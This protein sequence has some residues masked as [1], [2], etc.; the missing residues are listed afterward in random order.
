MT[1]QSGGMELLLNVKLNAEQLGNQL[2]GV[3]KA[4][5]S[6]LGGMFGAS[7]GG[8]GAGAATWGDG[9]VMASVGSALAKAFSPAGV[10]TAIGTGMAAVVGLFTKWIM[11]SQTFQTMAGGVFKILSAMADL[12]LMPFIPL[13][14]RFAQWMISN[15]PQMLAAGQKVADVVTRFFDRW[16]ER[17]DNQRQMHSEAVATVQAGPMGSKEKYGGGFKGGV[18]S[19]AAFQGAAYEMDGGMAAMPG[20]WWSNNRQMG[21]KVPGSPGQGVPTMLH[22]G[23]IV[24]PQDIAAG[25][26]QFS[27]RVAAWIERFQQKEL[28]PGGVL[29]QWYDKMFG[30][31]IIP[32]MWANIRGMFVSMQEESATTG[33]RIGQD[34]DNID[35]DQKSFWSKFKFWESW[36]EIWENI[37][38]KVGEW[39][40]LL[41]SKLFG[42]DGEEELPPTEVEQGPSISER[43]SKLVKGIGDWYKNLEIP[44]PF[45]PGL[46]IDVSAVGDCIIAAAKYVAG[47]FSDPNQKWSLPW[48]AVEGYEKVKGFLVSLPGLAVEG[49]EFLWECLKRIPGILKSFFTETI[50]GWLKS[51]GS[52]IGG[53]FAKINFG[54]IGTMI[55]DAI[56]GLWAKI[57]QVVQD[58]PGAIV[59]FTLGLV[60]MNKHFGSITGSRVPIPAIPAPGM[61]VPEDPPDKDPDK[62][63]GG[64]TTIG[65]PEEFVGSREQDMA[66]VMS[67]GSAGG[68]RTSKY[69]DRIQKG[70]Q[71]ERDKAATP[72]G[73]SHSAESWF[74]HFGRAGG[75]V[76][77]G[78]S[79]RTNISNKSINVTVNSSLS[80]SEI[81]EDLDRM[82]SMD[83]ASFFNSVM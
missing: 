31:S 41:M 2:G 11:S 25:S 45:F 50:P 54:D 40:D 33:N 13:M 18:K 64:G 63:T 73:W 53:W 68:Y 61:F 43:L 5:P 49:M 44:I 24:I 76:G 71:M 66:S 30:H 55:G 58:I 7:Q 4:L 48:M 22:G 35:K 75:G 10:I 67:R 14:T 80:V 69:V 27:G 12:F 23:E 16:I 83:D 29:E 47:I 56:G 77:R 3:F 70:R 28:G 42:G 62:D 52:A 34:T 17:R 26:N 79:G 59:N 21:G 38:K 46:S 1:Q 8:G 51:A 15:M 19:L 32:E 74:D 39:K 60:G 72:D 36:G 65:E 82:T 6:Q 78:G 57:K 81:L 20:N 9:G 37:K